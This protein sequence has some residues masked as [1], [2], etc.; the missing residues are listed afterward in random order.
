MKILAFTDT[1]CSELA[2][3]RIKKKII[4][5]N[6]DLLISCGDLSNFSRGLESSAKFFN[7]FDKPCLIIPGNHETEE[8]IKK[9]CI[10]Y[11][12]LINLHANSY[13]KED[14]FFYYFLFYPN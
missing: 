11:K 3:I 10:K 13:Q 7:S 1:H 5:E 12:N 6:P 4:K 14:F 8:E 9:I 2:H